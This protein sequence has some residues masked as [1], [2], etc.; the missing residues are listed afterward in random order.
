[1]RPHQIETIGA[2]A[3]DFLGYDPDA[4]EY[5]PM[6]LPSG[7]GIVESIVP[8]TGISV[9]DTDPAN[10]VVSATGGGGGAGVTQS[11]VGYNTAGAS[12]FAFTANRVYMKKVTLAGN[13]LMTDIEGYIANTGDSVDSIMVAL[14]TDGGGSGLPD[15]LI[16]YNANPGTSVIPRPAAGT[17]GAARWLGVPISRYL[18][19]GDYWIAMM[20]TGAVALTLAY[21]TTATDYYYTSGGAWFADYGRYALSNDTNKRYSMRANVLYL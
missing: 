13:G 19:A 6:A 17:N 1:M 12:S 20:F 7:S 4:D 3:G 21:D 10:P 5:M 14:Y 18:T 8:G 15:K 16:A 11:Y 9:D 2:V